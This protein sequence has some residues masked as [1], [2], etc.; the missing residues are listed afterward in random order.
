MGSDG[1]CKNHKF[2]L[3]NTLEHISV[4]FKSP[5]ET[6]RLLGE[7]HKLHESSREEIANN[8]IPGIRHSW[9]YKINSKHEEFAWDMQR[10][11]HWPH[12]V[13]KM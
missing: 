8:I 1:K 7:V 6:W 5:R 10:G 3:V 12:L 4:D 2:D 11:Y 13:H 9:R